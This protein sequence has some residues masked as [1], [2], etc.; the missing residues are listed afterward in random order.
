MKEMF[1]KGFG[2]IMGIYAGLTA[3]EYIGKLLDPDK[4]DTE[5]KEESKEEEA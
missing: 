5:K 2:L 4:K 1:G 3:V